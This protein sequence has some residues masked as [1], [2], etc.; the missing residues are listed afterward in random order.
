MVGAIGGIAGLAVGAGLACGH[1]VSAPMRPD[2][3]LPTALLV[4]ALL[5]LLP[6]QGADVGDRLIVESDRVA[7]ALAS[8][9][10]ICSVVDKRRG[11]EWDIAPRCSFAAP[12][13]GRAP[14]S[15]V[16]QTAGQTNRVIH[17]PAFADY[18][19]VEISESSL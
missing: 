9:G 2:A 1:G 13:E 6:A 3:I 19:V 4:A 8:P 10:S 17:V 16:A 14:S 12:V 5:A 15:L 18:G 7:V 11:T